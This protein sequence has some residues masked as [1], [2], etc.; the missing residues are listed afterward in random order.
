VT[1]TVWDI[2]GAES[3]YYHKGVGEEKNWAIFQV[4]TTTW[5][6]CST[7]DSRNSPNNLGGSSLRQI[8]RS[9]ESMSLEMPCQVG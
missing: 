1:C 5:R 2:Y 9:E 3:K 4:W 8:S 6:Q 7:T